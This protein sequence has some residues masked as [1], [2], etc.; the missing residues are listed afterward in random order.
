LKYHCL[1]NAEAQPLN[2]YGFSLQ[3]K[4]GRLK[5]VAVSYSNL[6]LLDGRQVKICVYLDISVYI[7]QRHQLSTQNWALSSYAGAALA[8]GRA[9]AVKELKQSICEAIT[10]DSVYT[11]AWIGIAENDPQKTIRIAAAAGSGVTYVD[12]IRVSWSEDDPQGR[13]PTGVCI[14]TGKVEIL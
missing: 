14:R 9:Q 7:N 13:G 2:D 3:C 5:R 4:D 8:L 6:A 11:L 10:S 1:C 12:G